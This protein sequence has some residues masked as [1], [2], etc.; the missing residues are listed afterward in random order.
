[1]EANRSRLLTTGRPYLQVFSVFGLTP[2]PILFDKTLDKRQQRYFK[3]AYIC[4]AFTILLVVIYECYVNIM[5]L[6]LHLY[7]FHVEDFSNVMGRTAKIIVV[8]MIICNQLNMVVNFR[9]L[10]EIY[11]D[12]ADLEAEIEDIS[13]CFNGKRHW[14]TFRL[15]LAVS[16]GLW[17]AFLVKLAPPLILIGLGPFL[18]WA[19]KFLTEVILLM[20]QLKGPEYCLFVLL[21][22]E[23]I[24]RVRHIL[25]EIQVELEICHS[26]ERIQ[27][28]CVTLKR[29]QLLLG[30][31]WRL[32][33]EI[34]IYFTLS[35]TLLFLYNGLTILHII[36]WM[37]IK[38]ANPNDCCQYMR[39]GASLLLAINLLLVSY[40]CESCL[41][42]YLSITYILHQIA[43][44][45]VVEQ[46]P[47]LQRGLREYSLQ[48][49]H[50]K[51]LFTCGGLFDI[52]LKNF[53]GM[54]VT[55]FGY[56][57]I[58]IQFKIQG[59]AQLK[60]TDNISHIVE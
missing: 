20:L 36:N 47:M 12:I 38:Y 40:Y 60:Y 21:V 26:S 48:M 33:G 58:L 46:L 37:L 45:P 13:R 51:L 25:E 41:K 9:R 17:I 18:H 24:L 49:Q 10:G 54:V 52:N 19:N 31:I 6:Q 14:C 32:V 5:A 8:A 2:P 42:A 44:L 39:V 59:F 1:M 56:I 22:Y 35:M 43:K 50:L 53:G 34:G 30:Q 4:F 57:I 16:I 7:Q 55:I 3:A 23:L 11:E 28:L 27:E 29:N 15:R